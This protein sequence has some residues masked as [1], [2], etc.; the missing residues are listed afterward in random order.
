MSTPVIRMI[1]VEGSHRDAGLQI[2][3]AT[4]EA[5]RRRVELVSPGQLEGA[6]P[7]RDVTAAELPWLVEELAGAA[8]GAGVDPLALFAASIE[9]LEAAAP[10]AGGR[11]GR[12]SDLIAGPPA[13]A[14]GHLWVA[15]TNDLD[16]DQEPDLVAV[17]WRIPGDPVV[18]T[19]GIGPWIS[20]G[21]NSAGLALTGNELAP[22][23][24]RV[25]IPRLLQVRDIVRR[26]TLDDA[27]RAA[28]HPARASSYNNL[29]THRDGGVVSV[30][31]SATDAELIRP[32]PSGTLVHTNHYVSPRM[33][34]FEGDPAYARRSAVRYRRA[35]QLLASANITGDGLRASLCDHAGAPDS[36]CRHLAG[37]SRT[38]TVFWCVADVTRGEI[39]FGRGN[40]CDTQDQRYAF[41]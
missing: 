20:V 28:L 16:A 6:I 17:E 7:Y 3:R 26:S 19:I 11:D 5:V 24:N 37:R 34:A 21:F 9:E 35:L 10:V 14:D 27:V 1:R 40:P 23:D 32:G 33:R 18:L 15:H 12:C 4:A 41:A 30:E 31:G 22:N 8:E 13:T 29:L 36:I 38:K 39:T 25:G 2:G